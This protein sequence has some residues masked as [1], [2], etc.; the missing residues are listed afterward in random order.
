MWSKWAEVGRKVTSRDW[1]RITWNGQT[2]VGRDITVSPEG[3][4]LLDLRGQAGI[5][6][7]GGNPEKVRATA[8]VWSGSL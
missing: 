5:V 6:A 8:L 3:P 7:I 1:V 2:F 4:F